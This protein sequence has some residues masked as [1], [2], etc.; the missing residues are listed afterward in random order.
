MDT[1]VPRHKRAQTY[2]AELTS[3]QEAEFDFCRAG[4]TWFYNQASASQLDRYR[5]H[6]PIESK[7]NL[8]YAVRTAN[9]TGVEF[10]YRGT[11]RL[12]RDVPAKML[13]GALRQLSASWTRHLN[14]LGEW[15]KHPHPPG[16]KCPSS[17]PGFRSVHRGG[18][19]YWQVQDGSGP[20]P[21]GKLI[22]VT[23]KATRDRPALARLRVPGRIGPVQIR[24][25]RE[26]PADTMVRFASLRVDDLGR[27][28]V[29]IQYDTAQV[30]QPAP[31]GI[32]GVDVGVA[33]TAATSDG[34]VYDAP[35]LP[36]GQQ[37]RKDRLQRA[38]DRKRRLNECKHDE[39]VTVRGR[40]G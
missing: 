39:W 36:P 1:P 26:L 34:E 33:V 3:G 27:Y 24:Y 20:C 28:W 6:V 2:A 7:R 13:H 8:P 35:C 11:T 29:T 4:A 22:S 38:M 9:E 30:R 40:P 14:A 32:V 21:A 37:Q 17:P 23:R 16:E 12:I 25:H 15:R 31:S 18:S 10:P 5:H 19:L